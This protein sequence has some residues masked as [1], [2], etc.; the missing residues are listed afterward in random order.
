MGHP[1]VVDPKVFFLC[2]IM[3]EDSVASVVA[4]PKSFVFMLFEKVHVHLFAGS[5]DSL[6]PLLIALY[7]GGAWMTFFNMRNNFRPCVKYLVAA[8]NVTGPVSLGG[9]GMCGF[10]VLG[11]LFIRLKAV[12]TVPDVAPVRKDVWMLSND[13]LAYTGVRGAL[14]A[15]ALRGAGSHD[16]RLGREFG[17]YHVF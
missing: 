10:G 9:N 6:T 15:A 7:T 16:Q 2:G 3:G 17:L 8:A 12:S 5:N 14:M 11:Q 4:V 1:R 13:M